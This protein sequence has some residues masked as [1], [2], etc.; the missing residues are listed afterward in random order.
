LAVDLDPLRPDGRRDAWRGRRKQHIDIPEQVGRTQREPTAHALRLL[1][2]CRRQQCAGQETV[3]R[4]RFEIARAAAQVGQVQRAAFGI[5]DDEGRGAR[6]CHFGE[7]DAACRAQRVRDS[8]DGVARFGPGVIVK[9]AVQYGD[10]QA[11]DAERE[12]F[13]GWLRRSRQAARVVRI[14][15]LNGVI[16]QRQVHRTACKRPEM[17]E[18]RDEGIAAVARQPAKGG[19]QPEDAAQ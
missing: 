17:V 4:Q 9:V 1:H 6:A 7:F 18:T 13:D 15:A 16:D 11:T 5:A 8:R 19:L 2:P 14:E 12:R 10:S 3:A